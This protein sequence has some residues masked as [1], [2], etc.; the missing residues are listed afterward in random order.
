MPDNPLQPKDVS[1]NEFYVTD[2]IDG[3][4][5]KHTAREGTGVTSKLQAHKIVKIL[6]EQGKKD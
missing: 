1:S 2:L 5:T 3:T 6:W 4:R